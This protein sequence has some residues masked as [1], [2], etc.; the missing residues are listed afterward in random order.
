MKVFISWSGERSQILAQALHGWLPLTLH[1]V[2]PWLSKSDIDAGDR[3]ASEVG[4]ELAAS[5]YGIICITRE[6]L[7]SPWIL[8]EAGALAKSMEHGRV[9]PLLLD[10][11][12]K[13]ISG[14]LAQFQAK[15]VERSGLLDIVTSINRLE[16]QPIPEGRLSQLFDSLWANF[17]GKVDEIP[18]PTGLVKHNRPQHE[19]LEELV[20]GVRGLDIRFRESLEDSPRFRRRKSRMHPMMMRELQHTLELRPDDPMTI[21]I[22]SSF[23]KDELPWLYELGSE[24]YR[25]ASNGNLKVRKKAYHRFF[26]ALRMLRRGPF[27]EEFGDDK[28]AYMLMRDLEHFLEFRNSESEPDLELPRDESEEPSQ[29]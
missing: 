13:D 22:L 16:P 15:K 27:L 19:I 10:V 21:L 3:W 4:K 29:N 8:F 20:S 28:M 1:F 12:F 18:T 9:I 6:N 14:P 7:V 26:S 17:E 24:A 11:E 2:E 23:F 25:A 5:N